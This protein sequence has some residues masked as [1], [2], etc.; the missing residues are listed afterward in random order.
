MR[1]NASSKVDFSDICQL[2]ST[3]MASNVV[4]L[5]CKGKALGSANFQ[6]FEALEELLPAAVGEL[7]DEAFNERLLEILSTREN[8]NLAMLG[9]SLS[10]IEKYSAM[11]API[12]MSG[13]RLGTVFIYRYD[14]P[15]DIDDIILCE[16]GTNVVGLEMLRSV[17][18]ESAEESRRI[19]IV[20]SAI[21]SLSYSELSAIKCVFGEL[22]GCDGIVIASRLADKS[23]I[24]RSI[25]VNA[26]RKFEGAGVIETRSSGMKGTYIKILNK[27]VHEELNNL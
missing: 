2:L 8:V 13:E 16:Y 1:N 12:E 6:G 18:E 3:I 23:G 15:Y 10:G 9:F 7:A 17:N 19:S 24:T 27:A 21:D 11:I 25:I 5:S 20:R 14:K 22:G 26:I 4:V